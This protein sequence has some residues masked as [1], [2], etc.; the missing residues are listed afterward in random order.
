[1]VTT[2]KLDEAVYQIGRLGSFD[3]FN[4]AR[5]LSSILMLLAA[6]YKKEGKKPSEEEF[7]RLLV[8]GTGDLSN[9]EMNMINRV[10]LSVVMRQQPNGTGW[11]AVIEPRSGQ[12]MFEDIG[13]KEMARLVWGVVEAHR[14]ID[15]FSAPSSTSDRSGEKPKA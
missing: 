3:Q 11:A 8:A 1:M 2:I 7:A 15:F 10:C 6:M 4:I 13:L 5:K 9:E 14:I 12:L